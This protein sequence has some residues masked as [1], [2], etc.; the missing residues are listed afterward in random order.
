[1]WFLKSVNYKIRTECS[2][3]NNVFHNDLMQ[4]REG[5]VLFASTKFEILCPYC[6]VQLT[7]CTYFLTFTNKNIKNA[8][9]LGARIREALE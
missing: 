3:P 4:D 5:K 8:R 7:V 2:I 6:T 1:M 9:N